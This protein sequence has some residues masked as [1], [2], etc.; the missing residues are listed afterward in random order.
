MLPGHSLEVVS[1]KTAGAL[2]VPATA[3][4]VAPQLAAAA[5]HRPLLKL[6]VD[7]LLPRV[8]P[9]ARQVLVPPLPKAPPRPCQ[10]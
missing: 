7:L 5:T 1:C 10:T 6:R 9:T 2:W 8:M 4:V 3:A